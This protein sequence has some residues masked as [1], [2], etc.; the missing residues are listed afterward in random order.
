MTKTERFP[1]VQCTSCSKEIQL[2]VFE[3]HRQQCLPSQRLSKIT[4]H[5][6]V[7]SE[8]SSLF[9]SLQEIFP[10]KPLEN[11]EKEKVATKAL[12]IQQ[13]VEEVLATET[14]Y[15]GVHVQ[16]SPDRSRDVIASY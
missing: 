14:E 8:K 1:M 5:F 15:D 11:L 16:P 12:D 13:A 2:S 4:G 7:V 10:D 9:T 3:K 6:P